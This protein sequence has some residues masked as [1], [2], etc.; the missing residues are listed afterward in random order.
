MIGAAPSE[1]QDKLL[2]GSDDKVVFHAEDIR[3]ITGTQICQVLVGFSVRSAFQYHTLPFLT[4]ICLKVAEKTDQNDD[5]D[6]H[7]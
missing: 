7:S 5:G 4:I 2:S 1:P 3:D 6:R